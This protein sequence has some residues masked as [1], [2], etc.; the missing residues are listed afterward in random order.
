MQER[1]PAA[2]GLP[3]MPGAPPIVAPTSEDP[4][5]RLS[6]LAELHDRG[7]LTDAE[8]ETQKKKMLGE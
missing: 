2:F 5:D 3:G 1:G 4:L 8:F 7:V 6:K